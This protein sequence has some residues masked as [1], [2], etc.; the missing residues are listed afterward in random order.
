M[1]GYVSFAF[2]ALATHVFLKNII[3]CAYRHVNEPK[4]F[5]PSKNRLS[6]CCAQAVHKY[7]IITVMKRIVL[8]IL[9]ILLL[10]DAVGLAAVFVYNEDLISIKAAELATQQKYREEQARSDAHEALD[11]SSSKLTN[12][13]VTAYENRYP[14]QTDEGAHR[15][16]S[17][18]MYH[19]VY[20]PLDP[21]M[22]RLDN[23][24]ISTVNLE[25]QLK[26]LTDEGYSFPTWEEVRMYI[27][28][29]IDLPEKSV[30]LTFD[31]G[32]DGFRKNG[33]PLLN[34]YKIPATAFI[35]VS[36]NGKKWVD[37]KDD[38]PY[39]DLESHSYDMHRPGGRVGHGGVMTVLSDI[40][41]YDDLKKS[42][43]I[44]GNS[45]AF[46]YPFG[47][48]DQLGRCRDAVDRAGFLIAV[49]T[50]YGKAYPGADPLL[51]PRMRVN[52]RN[53]LA[54]FISLL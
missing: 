7:D 27:D 18:L 41:I 46:A 10:I 25:E 28:G 5:C 30:V 44:L 9:D 14:A 39:L 33:V 42:Q 6:M 2:Y 26:Y 47:D 23:N 45:N 11:E 12:A 21:P 4:H 38:Y 40:Q 31:D 43:T 34:K 13:A 51:L 32:A 29:E 8:V 22:T 48:V 19:N 3:L 36:K 50:R 17:I 54:A 52:G 53:S 35:I 1:R 16:L 24:Y 49:T 37:N 20:D 15:G